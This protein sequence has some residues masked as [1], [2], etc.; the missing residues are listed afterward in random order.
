[1]HNRNDKK[2]K[3]YYELGNRNYIIAFKHV[4]HE[5][6]ANLLKG[7]KGKF[8]LTYNDCEEIRALYSGFNIQTAVLTYAAGHKKNIVGRKQ[9][10]L[11]ITNYKGVENE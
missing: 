7:I 5:I 4:D 1:M 2:V 6:L 8:L 3:K 10:E 9:V 11:I